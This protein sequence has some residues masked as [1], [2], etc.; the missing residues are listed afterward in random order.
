MFSCFS[1]HA[2]TKKVLFSNVCVL[3][4]GAKNNNKNKNK[5]KNKNKNKT[6]NKNK[7]KTLLSGT[8]SL[9]TL[10]VIKVDSASQCPGR[11]TAPTGSNS[12]VSSA[13]CVLL[14]HDTWFALSY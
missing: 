4:A 2:T 10:R 13:R 12:A 7:N 1:S 11:L 14:P 6:K 9:L 8:T 3:G 5:T